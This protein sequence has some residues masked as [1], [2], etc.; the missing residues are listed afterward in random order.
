MNEKN[1]MVSVRTTVYLPKKLHYKL[2]IEA[3]KRETSMTQLV[4]TAV[5]KEFETVKRK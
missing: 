4:I 1:A 3:V 5:Q 2:K